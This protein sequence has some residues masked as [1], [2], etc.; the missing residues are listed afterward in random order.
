[1]TIEDFKRDII[2]L[3]PL[4]QRTAEQIVGNPD[5]AEDIV[6]ETVI[7]LWQQHS[8]M[9]SQEM[10]KFGLT[11]VKRRS[12]DQLRKH[13]PTVSIDAECLMVEEI[14]HDDCEER[15]RQV[16]QLVECLPQR[17][18]DAILMKY[19]EGMSNEEIEQVT[20]MSSTHLYVT[21]SRA[22]KTLRNAINN[23]KNNRKP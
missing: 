10:E 15:Y 18:R 12:I 2:H 20:G 16:R 7:T 4:L 9:S 8:S 11:V 3:Q 23:Q 19:E 21:L 13:R 17:Q 1:M 6:Q 5:S 22:Y 14:Q